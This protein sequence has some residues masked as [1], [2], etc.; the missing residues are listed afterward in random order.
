[1][2]V[3]IRSKDEPSTPLWVVGFYAP[4]GRWMPESDHEVRAEAAERVAWLN[5]SGAS[6]NAFAR[7]ILLE[8][9]EYFR[10]WNPV[11]PS[12]P[13]GETTMKQAV[14][15]YIGQTKGVAP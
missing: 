8:I 13:F 6:A 4:N 7:T 2:Y 11:D 12:A 15:D 5:G 10:H 9:H 3:Y 14:E 1:M